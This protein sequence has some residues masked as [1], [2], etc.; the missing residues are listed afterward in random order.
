VGA[1]ALQSAGHVEMLAWNW[2][3]SNAEAYDPIQAAG[4][5]IVVYEA[6]TSNAK[7]VTR[8]LFDRLGLPWA[9]ETD[10][11]LEQSA[12][13]E[14][15]YYSVYRDPAEAAGRWRKELGPEVVDKV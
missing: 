4:G 1:G 13:K 7:G 11:F 6:L 2:L 12:A 9:P 14:G 15:G 5:D 10:A 3:L 8:S